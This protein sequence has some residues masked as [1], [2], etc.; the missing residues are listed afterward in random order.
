MQKVE[1]KKHGERRNGRVAG[2]LLCALLLAGCVVAAVLLTRKAEEKPE[3]SRQPVTGSIVQRNPEELESMTIIPRNGESWTAVQLEDGSL[4]LEEENGTK[5][6][7]QRSF[8][9]HPPLAAAGETPPVP[10]DASVGDML[11]DAA[12]HLTYEDVF[13]E[14]RADWEPEAAEFGL[15]DPLITAV[16]RYTDGTET[17]VRIGN[18]ADPED[19]VVYYMTVD[20]DDRLYAV[21]AGTVKDLGIEKNVLLPVPKLQIHSALLDRITVR[22]GNGS[23]RIE[24]V[25]KGEVSDQDAAENWILTAPFRYPADYEAMKNLKDGAEKLRLS[26]YVDSG[27][28]ENLEKYGLKEPTTVL[29]MHMAAGSTGTVGSEG[30]YDVSDWEE[31]TKTLTIGKAKSDMVDYVLYDG[32]IYTISHFSV[33]AFTDT[34]ALSTAAR[35]LVA[36]PLNSLESV[37]VAEEGKEPVRYGLIRFDE[38]QTDSDSGNTETERTIRCIRN[39]EEIP[40]ETFAAAYERM[41]TVTVSGKLPEGYEAEEAHTKYTF[42]TVSGGTHTV[43]LCDYDGIHD[44]VIMDGCMEFY[45][46]KGAMTEL[47]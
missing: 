26:T 20:G 30:V 31:R 28:E 11:V 37:T 17:T 32:K 21:G 29:E 13:T 41:L 27:T 15:A 33:S 10:I 4:G 36:T 7:T 42:R 12:V 3:P 22:N 44:A 8:G 16:F 1:R 46:I 43:E 2:V 34:E 5:G 40:Y 25:L 38:E 47:P 24:W 9:L 45:L 35:Y 19:N 14:N 6:T 39:G 18:S 23:S